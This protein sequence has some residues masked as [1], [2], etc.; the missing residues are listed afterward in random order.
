MPR[1]KN[2][3]KKDILQFLEKR[4]KQQNIPYAMKRDLGMN[5]LIVII[6]NDRGTIHYYKGGYS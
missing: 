2:A 3:K 4:P 1:Q 6:D 5:L